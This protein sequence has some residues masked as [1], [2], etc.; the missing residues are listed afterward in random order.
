MDELPTGTTTFLL[1]DIEGSTRLWERCPE[2]MRG[3]MVRHDTLLEG[4]VQ[5]HDGITIRPRGEGDSR[6]AVFW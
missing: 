2:E 1:T 5:R 4:C 3:A 6:F